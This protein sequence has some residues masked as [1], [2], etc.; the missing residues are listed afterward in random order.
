[1]ELKQVESKSSKKVTNG[2]FI[3]FVLL[4]V[5]TIG[6]MLQQ[7]YSKG[8]IVGDQLIAELFGH[9]TNSF[10]M[11]IFTLFTELGSKWGIGG[12]FIVALL[13]IWWKYRDYLAMILVTAC[14]I[15]SNELNKWI[16]E[17]VGRERPHLDES[18]YAEGFSFPSGHAMVGITFY[19]FIT[20]YFL[21]KFVNK[22]VKRTFATIMAVLIFLIGFSRIILN[23]HYPSD[24][25]AGFAI[26]FLYLSICIVIYHS[27]GR[28][29]KSRS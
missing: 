13:F 25:F 21:S 28:R 24:V 3:L 10:V 2:L 14:A 9:G 17:V 19:G 15:G 16:K 26:G 29:I 20:F 4:S 11:T 7:F 27:V 18:I 23:A 6:I 22:K 1:M 8:T 5:S 12:L